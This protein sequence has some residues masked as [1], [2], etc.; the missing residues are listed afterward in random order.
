[1]MKRWI[2]LEILLLLIP[3]VAFTDLKVNNTPTGA[4][5][6]ITQPSAVF[7]TWTISSNESSPITAVSDEG[8]FVLGAQV[9]GR[10]ETDL[11]VT[12]APNGTG[13]ATE[14]LLIPPDLSNRALKLKTPT[15][16]YQREFRSTT[17]GGSGQSSLTCRL[18]TSA[19]GNFSIAAVTLFFES[20][21]G[22]ATFYQNDPTARATVEVRYN[23]TGLL[24]AAWEVQEPNSSQFRVLQQVNYHLTY[25]DR[26]V[27]RT[28]AL[29]PLPS[30]VTG[31]HVLRFQILEPV[32]GFELPSVTYFV[33]PRQ[34]E[35]KAPQL[36]A[37]SPATNT[38]ITPE[39]SFQWTD[40]A[41][42][43]VLKFSVHERSSFNTILP[44]TPSVEPLPDSNELS[45]SRILSN[46]DIFPAKG[47]EIFSATLPAGTDRYILKTEQQKRLKPAT[48]YLWQVQA[49]DASGRVIAESELRSF[50]IS[51]QQTQNQ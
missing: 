29:P 30:V 50:Q 3:G 46:P 34:E 41:E 27:F 51:A 24:K 14:T 5:V 39:T 8:L 6:V 1:M 43:A 22:E 42:A 4:A 2:L 36:V 10:V 40:K 21:R 20:Q 12:I 15:F 37:L 47:V 11:T 7:V 32:S 16:F 19:Y 31:R 13:I 44:V 45:G 9:L 38:Q 48:W 28:P 17:T 35:P 26:I 23:G 25:G 18:S 33:K 49:L